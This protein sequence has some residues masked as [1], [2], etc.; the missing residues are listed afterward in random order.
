MMAPSVLFYVGVAER[1]RLLFEFERLADLDS[2]VGAES[3]EFAEGSG[4][5]AVS[6]GN[7]REGVALLN[8]VSRLLICGRIGVSARF[9]LGEVARGRVVARL[10]ISLLGESICVGMRSVVGEIEDCRGIDR[11]SH[12]TGFEMEVRACGSAGA[13]SEADGITGFDHLVRLHEMLVEVSIDSLQAVRMADDHVISVS[14][15]LIIGETNLAIESGADSIVHFQT[16]VDTLMHSAEAGAI[17]IRRCDL[18]HVRHVITGH[19]DDGGIWHIR[20]LE[21]VNASRIPPLG[22]DVD[23]RLI[24]LDKVDKRRLVDEFDL[25]LGGSVFG[26]EILM[27]R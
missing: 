16:D 13:A 22:I 1:V 23:L 25:L 14:F 26:E 17:A 11:I 3:V 12:I 18:A 4:R 7:R 9:I 19:V 8:S 15:G 21:R 10:L 24:F 20:L 5:D 27:C 2:V 6:S